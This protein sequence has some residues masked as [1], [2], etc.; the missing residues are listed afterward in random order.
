VSAREETPRGVEALVRDAM[1]VIT[2]GLIER[3]NPQYDSVSQ[4]VEILAERGMVVTPN[5][6]AEYVRVAE[7][8]ATLRQVCARVLL[9]DTAGPVDG[10]VLAVA[11][12]DAGIDLASERGGLR[13]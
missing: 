13:G 6:A 8:L 9:D 10:E 2:L 11:L 3:P 12:R 1:R 5:A 4:A 7:E